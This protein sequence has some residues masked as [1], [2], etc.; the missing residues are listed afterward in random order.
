MLTTMLYTIDS[1]DLELARMKDNS[2][3]NF[4]VYYLLIDVLCSMHHIILIEE[5]MGN[6]VIN[7]LVRI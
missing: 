3:H 6:A 7:N 1:F 4:W 2:S 5:I